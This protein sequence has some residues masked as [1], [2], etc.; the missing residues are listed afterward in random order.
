MI[1]SNKVHKRQHYLAAIWTKLNHR[2]IP[3][4]RQQPVPCS[5][6]F[7]PLSFLLY[8]SFFRK[9]LQACIF[10]TPSPPPALLK[11]HLLKEAGSAYLKLQPLLLYSHYPA[12]LLPLHSSPYTY[13][14]ISFLL[15]SSLSVCFSIQQGRHPQRGDLGLLVHC[16]TSRT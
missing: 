14:N 8:P 7:P 6:P 4:K 11:N 5:G 13:Y 1:I 10:L 15:L 16:Y 9:P 3:Q 12:L 2:S